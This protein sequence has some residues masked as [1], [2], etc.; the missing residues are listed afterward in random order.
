MSIGME[1]FG[2]V[3]LF[4]TFDPHPVAF[5]RVKVFQL[6][7]RSCGY[8]IDD[9]TGGDAVCPKCRAN[10]WERFVLPGSI[11]RNAQRY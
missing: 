1:R 9:V 8:E 7:C 3:G 6:Q 2:A 11:L 4:A 5:P 10:S